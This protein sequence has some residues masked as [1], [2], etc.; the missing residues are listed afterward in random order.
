MTPAALLTD[1]LSRVLETVEAVLDG[2]GDDV[3][4]RTPTPSPGWCGT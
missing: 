4:V 1:A 2:L 3:L